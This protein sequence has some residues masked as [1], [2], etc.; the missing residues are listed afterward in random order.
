MKV[1]SGGVFSE[2][3]AGDWDSLD[4]EAIKSENFNTKLSNVRWGQWKYLNE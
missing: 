1:K 4:Q 2:T 3:G